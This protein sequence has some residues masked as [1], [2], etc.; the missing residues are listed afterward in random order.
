MTRLF[1]W[2][3]PTAALA[4]ALLAGHVVGDFYLQWNG[5]AGA[6]RTRHPAWG[7]QIGH[8]FLVALATGLFL[9]PLFS[10]RLALLGALVTLVTHFPI[11]LVKEQVA[12]SRRSPFAPF[13][14]DQ[15]AH[16]LVIAGLVGVARWWWPGLPSSATPDNLVPGGFLPLPASWFAVG[17]VLLAFAICW[18]P[19]AMLVARLLEG[20]AREEDTTGPAAETM[21]G[22][23]RLIG[24]LERWLALALMLAG[25]WGAVGLVVA[26]KSVVRFRRFEGQA[27]EAFAEQ[28]LVGTLASLL[29]A[30]A[31]WVLAC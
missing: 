12:A 26:A 27:G 22:G 3:S 21:P 14:I 31:A 1:S 24:I 15:A 2:T 30:T 9:A 5:L 16:L 10:P 20:L 19:G 13:A 8:A 25:A 29:V 4:V 23:G 6:K 11:D 7:A 17:R 28:F 18:K